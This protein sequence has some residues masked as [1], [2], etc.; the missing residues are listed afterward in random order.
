LQDEYR[1]MNHIIRL[2]Q[3][4]SVL[5]CL[6]AAS[7]GM[8]ALPFL[9][10]GLQLACV[11]VTI[12]AILAIQIYEQRKISCFKLMREDLAAQLKELS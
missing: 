1:R 10:D 3:R 5:L 9:S 8:Y 12:A 4:A 2:D 6:G 7:V 11:A